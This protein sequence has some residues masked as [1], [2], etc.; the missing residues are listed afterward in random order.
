MQRTVQIPLALTSQELALLQATQLQYKEIYNATAAWFVTNKLTAK[1][2][3]HKALYA[4]QR[5]AFPNFPSALLQAARDN[6]SASVKSYNSNY[7]KKRWTKTPTLS[8]AMTMQ[9]DK[10]TVSLRG[11]LLTFSTIEKRIKTLITLPKWFTERY[12]DWNFQA[13]SVG[14]D[15]SGQPFVNLSYRSPSEPVKRVEGKTVG[16]DRGIHVLVSTSEGGEYSGKEVRKQRRRYLYNRTTLQQKG[17]RSAKRRLKALSGREKRFMQD[18]NHVVSKRL[19]SDSLVKIYV[20]EALTGISQR[21]KLAWQKHSN[22]RLSDWAHNQLLEFLRYKSEANGISLAF[23]DPAYT[24]QQCSQC[25]TVAKD[26]RDRSLYRCKQCGFT[27]HA[28]YNAAVNIRAKYLSS[29]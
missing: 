4:Q 15:K 18:V 19:A 7:P 29:V 28:D 10:R 1:S 21:K 6:A 9:L 25:G 27:A 26:A 16:L 20:L 24:S 5:D 8:S 17:T 11:S 12:L 14:V 3:A 2:L 23:V 13:A 22:K